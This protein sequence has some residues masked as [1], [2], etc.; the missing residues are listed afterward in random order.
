VLV[1]AVAS[2]AYGIFRNRGFDKKSVYR[3]L[4]ILCGARDMNLDNPE[5]CHIRPEI[6]ETWPWV[7]KTLQIARLF[8]PGEAWEVWC[9]ESGRTKVGVSF[10]GQESGFPGSTA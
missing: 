1:K 8:I 6:W 3:P 4:L 9:L 5:G 10:F 2:R 7:V